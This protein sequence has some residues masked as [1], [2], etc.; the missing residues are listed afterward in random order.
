M[1]NPRVGNRIIILGC[2]GSGK[3]AFARELQRLTGL[4]LIHLDKVW[5]RPDRTHISRDEFDRRLEAILRG[6]KWIVD[7]DYSRTYEPRFSACDTVV[8]LDYDEAVCMDGIAG[9]VGKARDD[10]PWVED[11]LDPELVELVENYRRD[12]R[13]RIYALIGKYPEKRSLVFTTRDEA[14]EWLS[15]FAK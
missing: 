4:P 10:I 12:N 15:S 13:P 9:R 1:E 3:S 11:R 6:E 14:R 7:G 8:F 5:W 2:S